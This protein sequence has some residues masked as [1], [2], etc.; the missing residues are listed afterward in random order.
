[1][2]LGV[3]VQGGTNAGTRRPPAQPASSWVHLCPG[4]DRERAGMPVNVVLSGAFRNCPACYTRRP[5][6]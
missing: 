2:S 3:N 6:T 1:M 4:P 5:G